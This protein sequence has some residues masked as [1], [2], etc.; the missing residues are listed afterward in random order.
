LQESTINVLI[1]KTENPV[2]IIKN[3]D[4]IKQQ[5][6]KMEDANDKL[7]F[8]QKIVEC[9][10]EEILIT[11]KNGFIKFLNPEAERVCGVKSK[12][13]INK[14]VNYLEK[15]KIISK[16]ITGEVIRT[17]KKVNILQQLK[18]GK[19]VL[20][21]AVPIFDENNNVMYVICTSK[22]VKE[23]NN[24]M[25]KIEE[26]EKE[27]E[28]KNKKIDRLKNSM[29]I[30]NDFVFKS[31]KMEIIRDLILRIAPTNVTVMVQGETGVGKEV[32][33]RLIHNFSQRSDY[34]LIKIN[35][36]LIPENLLESELFGYESGA[37]TGAINDG[38][39]GKIEL[40]HKGTLFL[41]EIGEM[42][43]KLQVKLLD[44]LQ[45]REITRVGG[46]KKIKIDTRVIVATNRNLKAMVKSGK[47]RQDLYYRLNVLPI[48]ISPLRDRKSDIIALT[49]FFLEKLNNKYNMNKKLDA[50]VINAFKNHDWPGNV[51]E[52]M[53]VLERLILT[54]S[55]DVIGIDKLS[56][57]LNQEL[58]DVSYKVICN[59]I[60]SLKAAKRELESQMV[61]RAYEKYQSTYKAAKV[62]QVDQST[63]V[64]LLKKYR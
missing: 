1:D 28:D 3:S 45:D 46:T 27:L 9:I 48:N 56:G 62:L 34:S 41:D 44:F 10:E 58:E 4:I 18:N 32:V 54:S 53:H 60:F 15:E 11:D 25:K 17:K 33:T 31:K 37:F 24:I 20:G 64:R 7:N 22:N 35:C 21:T 47:F 55:S 52:L 39:I 63:V 59:G 38:K 23:I 19:T 36:G 29:F 2:G 6:K 5:I 14:H 30:K 40:A 61:T 26:K 8:Y 16:N 51:R 49:D 42:P 43:L 50:E 57:I 13:V 12:E